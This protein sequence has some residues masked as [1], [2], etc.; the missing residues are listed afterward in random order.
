MI[1][2]P[3][4][5]PV[6]LLYFLLIVK[7]A[8]F[9]QNQNDKTFEI[10][11]NLE[12]FSTTYKQL[13]LHYVDETQPG[14]L[15]KTA[16][17]AMLQS[18]DPY[19]VYI[20][21]A[22][23]EDLRLFTEGSYEGIGILIMS[24]DG[25]IFISQIYEGYP[26]QKVGLMVGDQILTINGADLTNRT[27]DEV[28]T[29]LKGQANTALTLTIHRVGEH[30]PIEKTLIREAIKLKNVS[31]FAILADH[32]GY[33]KLDGFTEGA[34]NEVK[35]AFLKLKTDGATSLILDLR[36][37]GGGLMNEATDIVNLFV[38]RGLPVVSMKGKVEARNQSLSTRNEPIDR[39]IPIVVLI[40]RTS[41]SASEIVAG[42]LQDYDRAVIIGQRSF[43][44]GLVQNIL[45]LEYNAQLKIT[46]AK[47]Y[48]PSGRCVQAIDYADRDDEG[49][50]K[51]VPDSLRTAF[52][53]KGGRTVHDGDGIEP[54]IEIEPEIMSHIT[55]T[56]FMKYH[57]FD[58]ANLY[59]H[60]HKTFPKPSEFVVSDHLFN[61]F[62]SYLNGKDTDYKTQTEV[63]LEELEKAA[64]EE[65]YFDA[66]KKD[67]E[68]V[69]TQLF[70]DKDT[71]MNK[72]KAEIKT[73]LGLE[74]VN[75]YYYQRG[76]IEFALRNDKAVQKAI[77]ILNNLDVYR[78]ILR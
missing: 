12:I 5:K 11:K 59:H 72:N 74:L 75:R 45:P 31:Y 6:F 16:I 64:K 25:K 68:H 46:T 19:T 20:P 38:D 7:I 21:E 40:D 33:I 22:N 47:Y 18:L 73:V 44:K 55:A 41:A 57:F 13:H 62:K 28:S 26:A 34:A 67:L 39:D 60:K 14:K 36:G 70:H 35:E 77:E 3:L 32:V 42:A 8:G 48:I 76:T 1:K 23:I 29:L 30:K 9:S 53:T 27:N 63:I 54:D 37:N 17:D 2:M 49:R 65:K 51:K 78:T 15:I 61:E 52:K 66:I 69:K 71:D 10:L 4:K 56:L 24:R 50:A 58:F 43:G